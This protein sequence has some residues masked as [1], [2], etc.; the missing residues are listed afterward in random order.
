MANIP[1]LTMSGLTDG[2]P[3]NEADVSVPMLQLRD[4]I[5]NTLSGAHAFGKINFELTAKVI[6]SD[7]ITVTTTY[8]SV[9]TEGAAATDN[10][11][12]INGGNDGDVVILY[13]L[14]SGRVVTVKSDTGNITLPNGDMT[15][16]SVFPLILIKMGSTWRVQVPSNVDPSTFQARLTATTGVPVPTADVTAGTTLY[17][18]PYKGNN[19]ALLV[20]GKWQLFTLAADLQVSVASGI[21]A[22]TV[23][24]VFVYSNAGVPTLAVRA[25]STDTTRP[26]NLILNSGIY[27]CGEPGLS[28]YRYVGTV[29]MYTAGTPVRDSLVDRGI[30]N[31]YN[32]VPRPFSRTDSTLH[33]YTTV[34]WRVWN[35][36]AT[37][38]FSFVQGIQEQGIGISLRCAWGGAGV[39]GMGFLINGEASPESLAFLVLT[40]GYLVMVAGFRNPRLGWNYVQVAEIGGTG[41]QFSSYVLQ[42]LWEC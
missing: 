29:R 37:Q 16:D 39:G 38:Y 36:D 20:S 9:D 22:N 15:L 40:L 32:R 1:A 19:I 24:D 5:N 13:Q 33:T 3:A 17:L 11:A 10:L 2:T 8:N 18:T 34:A 26:N 31:F 30:W 23:Y 42:G 28:A 35:G 6:A 4:S 27:M 21:T 14:N 41:T 12:T 25:W 7:A